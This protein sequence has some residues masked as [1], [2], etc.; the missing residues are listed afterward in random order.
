MPEPMIAMTST[1]V[2]VASAA[3]M[4]TSPPRGAAAGESTDVSG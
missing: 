3:I 2:Q 1:A 4:L